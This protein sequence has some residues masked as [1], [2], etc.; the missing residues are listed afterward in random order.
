MNRPRATTAWHAL[1]IPAVFAAAQASETG[2]SEAE[3]RRRL[4][5][6][7]PNQLPE[8]PPPAWWAIVLR[9]FQSP[10]IYVLCVAAAVSLAVGDVT[11]AAFIALVLAINAG[12]GGYQEW[13]A[14]RSSRALRQLLHIRAAALRD[15]EVVELD[16][17]RIV[18]GDLI[19]LESGNRVPAD[20]RLLQ[21][22][23]LEVDESFLTGESLAV[24]KDP[25]WTGDADTTV[26]DRRNMAYAGSI[27]IRGRAQGVVV[28]T[29]T[30]TVVGQLALDVLGT[31]GGKPPL[32]E[33]MERFAQTVA[34][35][36]LAAVAIVALIG[37]VVH[38]HSLHDMF[39]FGVALAV[40][41]IPEGLPAALTVALSIATTRMARRGVIVRRLAAVEGLGSCTL[42]ASDKTGTL[43][44]N[45]LTVREVHLPGGAALEVTGEGFVPEGQ[46]LDRGR[47]VAAGASPEIAA[48]VCAAVLCNEA[49]LHRRDGH[50]VWRGDPTDVALL[51][52]AHK[53]GWVRETTLEAHPPVNAIPFE[54]E[55]RFAATF[56]RVDGAIRVFVKGAPERVLAMCDRLGGDGDGASGEA[57]ALAESLAARGYRVLALAEGPAPADL[58]AT[59]APPQP[60]GLT[61]LGFVA[62]IDPLR[63]GVREAVAA[64]GDAGIAVCMITGDHPVTALAIARDLGFA[65]D[66]AQVVSGRQLEGMSPE[67]LEQAVRE[68][69]V[70]ARVAPRQ[71]LELVEAARRVGHFV[72][73]TGDGVNDAPALR[74]ANIG[75]AM[76][77][78]GTDVAREAAELVISDDNFRTIV[79]G[80]EEGRVAYDNVRKV[81][82]LL[83]ST[84]A[85]EVV[86]VGLGLIFGLPLPLLA[87]QLLW[88][89]LVTNGIQGVAL[90]FEPSEGDV[91]RRRPRPPDEPIF[92]RLMI[93][94]TV[95]AATVMGVVGLGA[96][97]W[98]IARGWS[99]HAARNALLLL[100]VL[101]E[102][103]HIGNCRSET[104]S[105]LRLSPLRSPF[106]LAGA[107][108]ALLVHVVA[109]YLPLG[110]RVLGTEPVG[111]TTWVALLALALSVFLAMEVHKWTW[112][113]RFPPTGRGDRRPAPAP[114]SRRPTTSGQRIIADADP[115]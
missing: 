51:A 31:A 20:T 75:V 47:P 114:E 89:N 74:A 40:S 13:R 93:E 109:M 21:A 58:D 52:M 96:F 102:N 97:G 76:G 106:L 103:I 70:F 72:A 22:Q 25:A 95:V 67:R 24:L 112:A 63:P 33:R 23:G 16:A 94:R 37:V 50:W 73:V 43:T 2:L 60:S 82:Y 14:E 28:A 12:I 113:L 38:G 15:G 8:Q 98:M 57:L 17:E 88:L 11:D 1:E 29:G 78:S 99:E 62:M 18:P 44:C 86:V 105:A 100:L 6:F 92:N 32:L 111:L 36:V 84:G 77:R 104:R 27:I 42:I 101:F 107:L 79:A 90:A 71:K 4:E 56:H 69:R 115:R 91:L 9:Q 66:P 108:T 48:L 39:L 110:Q 3:A 34:Y 35:G 30:D 65:H 46:V 41:A 7:G 64:C 54:P 83:V 59:Q 80:V 26:G 55:H 45:E 87:V 53:L 49:D 81:I 85:A 61:F 5:R 68:A 19:W 10:L